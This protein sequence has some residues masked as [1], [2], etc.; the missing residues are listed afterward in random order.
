MKK[1]KIVLIGT[2]GVGKTSILTRLV[3]NEF[4]ENSQATI[5]S[6]YFCLKREFDEETEK[7]KIELHI[8]D[9]AGQERYRSLIS[10]YLRKCDLII[11]VYNV[12]DINY[13]DLKFWSKCIDSNYRGIDN[14]PFIY[15]IGNK[16]D[17]LKN[18]SNIKKIKEQ[19][20][21]NIKN[22]LSFIKH[23]IV[24]AKLDNQKEIQNL[25]NEIALD[26]YNN[27][28]IITEENEAMVK[29]SNLGNINIEKPES[30]SK[31]CCYY[32]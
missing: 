11:I 12:T 1:F 25:F 9:T 31:Y 32:F 20:S 8:W 7:K 24:S 2:S 3:K 21:D 19:V 16:R 22:E 10:M 4:Y 18:N 6:S 29:I 27:K 28:K 30:N 5:G 13:E 14:K 17:L 15:L 26:L 23:E